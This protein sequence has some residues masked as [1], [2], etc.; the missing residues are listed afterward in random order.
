[1]LDMPR[2]KFRYF[3]HIIFAFLT[4][5]LSPFLQAH[6]KQEPHLVVGIT[7]AYAPF[8][9]KKQNQ[10]IGFDVEL[11]R[12]ISQELGWKI[13]LKEMSFYDLIPAL[14]NKQ[15]DIAISA[16]NMTPERKAL[17]D[18]SVPYYHP[19]KIVWMYHKKNMSPDI[20]TTPIKVGVQG[21]SYFHLWANEKQKTKKNIEI[22]TVPS[23]RLL[24]K[25][26]KDDEVKAIVIE[27]MQAE[28]FC[29]KNPELMYLPTGSSIDGYGIA[30]QKGSQLTPQVNEALK[31]LETTGLL[32]ELNH[33]WIHGHNENEV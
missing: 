3:T 16:I 1:M 17:V 9:F 32:K 12:A 21:T 2:N 15:I 33:H 7:P 27:E 13:T 31:K 22:I 29:A 19:N 8:E 20:T 4:I 5:M 10:L 25:K 11:I 14:K 30:L 26:L 28:R 6:T 24:V 23:I 18:F